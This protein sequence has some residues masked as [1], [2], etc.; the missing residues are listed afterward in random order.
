[1][2]E[3]FWLRGDKQWEGV[4][5]GWWG[6]ATGLGE[7]G[8]GGGKIQSW[9]GEISSEKCSGVRRHQPEGCSLPGSQG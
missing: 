5:W 6:Q 8:A 4:K 3:H 2:M 1:M 9:S 7:N